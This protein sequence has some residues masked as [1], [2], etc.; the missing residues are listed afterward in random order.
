M[1]GMPSCHEA[2]D[3]YKETK[4]IFNAAS[5][6]MC[7]WSSNSAYVMAK[8]DSK[9]KNDDLVVKVLGMMWRILV[10][11]LRYPFL[12]NLQLHEKLTKRIMRKFSAEFLT[13]LDTSGRPC[14]SQ[15]Y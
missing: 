12:K 11:E 4:K 6:N 1:S 7:K 10:D 3:Y 5:M 8:F 2:L 13:R 14:S 9:D 15:S